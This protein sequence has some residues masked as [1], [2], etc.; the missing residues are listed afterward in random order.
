[1]NDNSHQIIQSKSVLEFVTI[2]NE[3]CLFLE[4]IEKYEAR[5]LYAYLQKILPLL[6]LKGSLIPA[7]E[8]SDEDSNERF[9]T[10][11]QWQEIYNNIKG[12][13]LQDDKFL[14]LSNSDAKDDEIIKASISEYLADVYQDMKDFILLMQKNTISAREN[15]I[16]AVKLLF[17][18]HWG[19]KVLNLN[20]AIHLVVFN[21]IETND[22][23]FSGFSP[24]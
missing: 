4:E 3:Y 10:Q 21:Q 2:A 12:K 15:A 1:M 7:I 20:K 24:N 22:R 9:V 6:Y 19:A 11:E 18:H 14:H 17:E 13:V 5:Y 16:N 23:L 8:V